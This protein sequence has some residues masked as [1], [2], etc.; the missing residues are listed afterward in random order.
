[1]LPSNPGDGQSHIPRAELPAAADDAELLSVL[2]PLKEPLLLGSAMLPDH[3]MA[4]MLSSS[5]CEGSSSKP[6]T[7]EMEMEVRV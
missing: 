3:Q 6:N 5:G 4:Q 2:K 1:M 7:A